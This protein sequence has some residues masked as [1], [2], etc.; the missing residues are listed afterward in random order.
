MAAA[1][2]HS[3]FTLFE[4]LIVVG[5]MA[6]FAGVYLQGLQGVLPFE[7]RAASRAVSGDLEYASQRAIT[8]GELHRW[9][10]DLDEQSFRIESLHEEPAVASE[11]PTHA[12]LLDA[13]AP[14]PLR[15]FRPIEN[16]HGEWRWLDEGGVWIEEVRVGS[17]GSRHGLTGILFAADGG[18]D[19]AEVLL[20]DES[21]RRFLVR[22][23]AF[24]GEIR[25][26]E[27]PDA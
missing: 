23:L 11:L 22:V 7:I 1:R 27:L 24:T 6:L 4:I 9:V 16:R 21:G 13:S 5:L 2:R 19:P 15:E 20:Q 14:R 18:A 12:E 3:G 26:E 10:I 8:S 25:V 17:S